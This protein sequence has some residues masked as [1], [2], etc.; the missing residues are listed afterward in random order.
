MPESTGEKTEKETPHKLREQRK[1]G[2]VMQ[3]KDVVTAAF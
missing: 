3:S 2:N 1:E